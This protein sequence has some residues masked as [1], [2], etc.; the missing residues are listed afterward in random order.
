[1]PKKPSDP[2]SALLL[3]PTAHGPQSPYSFP[4]ASSSK[5]H[6]SGHSGVCF[7]FLSV[8]ADTGNMYRQHSP[9]PPM[10]LHVCLSPSQPSA[11]LPPPHR[12]YI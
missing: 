6:A 4:D 7:S 8:Q 12:I 10:Q 9:P 5:E 1:M 3:P 11:L 2:P